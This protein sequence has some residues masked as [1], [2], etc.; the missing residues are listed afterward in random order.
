MS[1]VRGSG[2]ER[3]APYALVF[4]VAAFLLYRA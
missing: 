1:D 4:G 2:A 3:V